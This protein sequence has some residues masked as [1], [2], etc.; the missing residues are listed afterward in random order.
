MRYLVFGAGAVG[1][2]LAGQLADAGCDVTLFGRPRAIRAVQR[3][4]IFVVRQG[5]AHAVQRPRLSLSL[6]SRDRFDVLLIATQSWQVGDVLRV[7]AEL[8]TPEGR[9]VTLQDG[10]DSAVAAAEGLGLDVAIAGCAV[11]TARQIAPSAVELVG[12]SPLFT[13]GVLDGRPADSR[14]HLLLADL[15]ATGAR[16]FWSNRVM[17]HLWKRLALVASYG[18][19]GVISDATVGETR[20]LPESRMLVA[21]AVAEA[22]EVANAHGAALTDAD[23][24]EVLRT[25]TEVL[26]PE[27]TSAMHRDLVCGDPSELMDQSGAVVAY[28]RIAGVATPIHGMILSSQLPREQRARSRREQEH[29]EANT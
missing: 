7:A 9:V 18:G 8:L 28:G 26:A 12:I 19:V 21:R 20:A 24:A 3:D 25:Y 11:L 22:L 2:L 16:A 1:L 10:L 17:R 27:T 6:G 13:L 15:R 4:G 14:A 5:N 23:H 29:G